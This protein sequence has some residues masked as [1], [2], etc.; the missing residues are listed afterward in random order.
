MKVLEAELNAGRVSPSLENYLELS[1][2][3]YEARED[4][5]GKK[6]MLKSLALKQSEPQ[7][8]QLFNDVIKDETALLRM[9]RNAQ[10][11]AIESVM[12]ASSLSEREK[13]KAF[14][15]LGYCYYEMA[16]RQPNYGSCKLLWDVDH[17]LAPILKD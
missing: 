6:T 2:L 9:S 14:L 8:S 11:V 5:R 7:R 13:S 3:Y 4:S 16:S 1:R 12:E 10:C 17:W 15:Y